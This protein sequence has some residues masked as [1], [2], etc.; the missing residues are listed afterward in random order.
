[1]ESSSSNEPW[2][3]HYWPGFPGR[4]EFVRLIFEEAGVPYEEPA[5]TPGVQVAS[6]EVLSIYKGQIDT[7]FPIFAP[8]IIQ[9]GNFFL[10]QTPAIT[11]YLGKKFGL[12]PDNDIDEAR[13]HQ[14]SL[15]IADYITAGRA[16]FHPIKPYASH[17][18]QKEE[19]KPFI[20]DFVVERLPK[21]LS[22]FEA[23]LAYAKK[24]HPSSQ[25]MYVV[26]NKLTYVDLELFH[27]LCATE[28]QFN[29]AWQTMEVPLVKAFTAQIAARPRIAEY[30]KSERRQKFAGDSMM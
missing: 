4:G 23:I 5:R 14:V 15:C 30:L 20:R 21:H 22:H 3:L 10:C 8:P 26:G 25:E 11:S 19:S 1:M 9:K 18:D 6:S 13:A 24:T 27:A 16:P 29:E 7:G 12:Y 17:H 2:K 28:S